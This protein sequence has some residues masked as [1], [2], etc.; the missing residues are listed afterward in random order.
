V[1]GAVLDGPVLH[2]GGDDVGDGGVEGFG[3]ADGAREALE[4][5]LGEAL[6]HDAFGEDVGAEG[7]LDIITKRGGHMGHSVIVLPMSL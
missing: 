3:E 4:D 1:G 7:F 2:G 5:I 6:L